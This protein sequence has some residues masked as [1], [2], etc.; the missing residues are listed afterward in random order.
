MS[1]ESIALA[2][3]TKISAP[4]IAAGA[5]TTSR[6]LKHWADVQ[7][8][9][10]PAVFQ[11]QGT[12]TPVRNGL[13]SPPIWHLQFEIYIYA[14]ETD[15]SITPATKLNLLLDALEAALAPLS[16]DQKQTLGGIVEHCWI[17]GAIET[18]EGTLGDQAMAVV[19]VE[20]L[21][22]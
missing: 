6:K 16:T 3:F 8:A 12:E 1:R 15:P 22:S 18:D 14:H 13:A 7:P 20:V 21:F 5:V 17:S 10:Q 19:P 4:M 2:L 11:T 9:D